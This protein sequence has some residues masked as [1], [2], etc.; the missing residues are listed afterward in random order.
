MKRSVTTLAFLSVSTFSERFRE[1][2]KT[3]QTNK[4]TKQKKPRVFLQADQV[5]GQP[6]V[7]RA[8]L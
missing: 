7:H 4:Q 6:G 1:D 2:L 3:K 8:P 5:Q